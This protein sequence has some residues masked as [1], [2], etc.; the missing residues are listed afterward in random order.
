M[1]ELNDY[2]LTDKVILILYK[3]NFK[4]NSESNNHSYFYSIFD[5]I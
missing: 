3:K 4:Q 1:I 2:E 5:L